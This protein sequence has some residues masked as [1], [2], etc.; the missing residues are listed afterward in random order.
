MR[1]DDHPARRLF[2]RETRAHRE[3]AADAL[4]ARHDV[5]YDA[6]MLIGIKM[7]GARDAALDLVEYQHQFALVANVAQRLQEG[8]RRRANAALALNRRD[9]EAGRIRSEARRVGKECVRSCK[10]R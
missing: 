9:E 10:S 1:A 4:G 3:T 6:E 8:L 7:A 2:G 5:G